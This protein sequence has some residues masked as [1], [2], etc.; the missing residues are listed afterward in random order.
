MGSV[1]ELGRSPGGGNGNPLQYSCLENQPTVHRV[2][3]IPSLKWYFNFSKH[4]LPAHIIQ[5]VAVFNSVAQRLSA[6]LACRPWL[7][8]SFQLVFVDR[9]CTHVDSRL[10]KGIWQCF[11]F[12]S[13]VFKNASQ[14]PQC[15]K[16]IN[17]LL[18]VV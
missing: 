2:T 7:F 4:V 17:Q 3:E 14:V 12:C 16:P 8:V 18:D 11:S 15:L 9:V 13:I 5:L 6:H 10:Y 1:P